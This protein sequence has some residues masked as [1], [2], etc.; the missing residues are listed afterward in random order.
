[1]AAKV[2]AAMAERV[3]DRY[4]E[5]ADQ[6]ERIIWG[7]K[8]GLASHC[9]WKEERVGSDLVGGI[10]KV[11]PIEVSLSQPRRCPLQPPRPS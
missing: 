7:T 2:A 3:V 9:D 5:T 1:M 4:C 10:I 8:R 11:N 6:F